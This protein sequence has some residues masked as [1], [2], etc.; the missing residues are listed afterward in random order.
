VNNSIPNRKSAYDFLFINYFKYDRLQ[1]ALYPLMYRNCLVQ[2]SEIECYIDL[3]NY[4][5]HLFSEQCD[6]PDGLCI[7]AS[8][9][10]FAAHIRQFFY[11]RYGIYAHIYMAYGN[12]R[13]VYPSNLCVEYDAHSATDR[14]VK[15]A[16]CE[17]ISQGLDLLE[18]LCKYLPNVYFVHDSS[19]EP[20]V[21]I[22]TLIKYNSK[23]RK[24]ARYVFTRDLYAMQLAAV[25]PNTHIIRVKKERWSDMTYTISYYD[26]FKKMTTELRLKNLIG[27][28]VSPELYSFYMAIAGCRDREIKS[29]MNYPLT[30]RYIHNLIISGQILNG[31]NASFALN[32]FEF[33]NVKDVDIT[34]RFQALDLIHQCN[35]YENM[36]AY[37]ALTSNL[38]NL[39]DPDAVKDI[40]N[41]YF[42]HYPLDLDVL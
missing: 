18:S 2:G 41:K 28:G 19:T 5:K 15:P 38:V 36:P 40:N 20:A 26:F 1:E 9:V 34:P 7:T 8:I 4:T 11:T 30:D 32:R 16:I 24:A 12:T 3:N 29:I 25:T 13:P 17:C 35:V 23:K 21:L 37:H 6:V 31:Y 10:N 27:E 33:M 39:Y 14:N 22:R 42:R